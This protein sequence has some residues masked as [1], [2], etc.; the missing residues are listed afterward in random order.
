MSVW[1]DVEEVM[2]LLDIG[3]DATMTEHLERARQS[4]IERVILDF[5]DFD[6]DAGPT[7]T[8]QQAMLRA[9]SVLRTNAP[10]DGWRALDDDHIYQS[11]RKGHRS[12]FGVA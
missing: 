9:T 3:D 4:A 6:S 12:K 11:Y 10:D 1:P 8:M 7:A 5:H 2:R